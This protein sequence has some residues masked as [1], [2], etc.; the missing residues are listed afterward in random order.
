MQL[1]PARPDEAHEASPIARA[2]GVDV[3][4]LRAMV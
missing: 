3:D 2:P 4:R 1:S